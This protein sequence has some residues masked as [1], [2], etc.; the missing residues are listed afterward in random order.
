MIYFKYKINY[1]GKKYF[2]LL[3]TSLFQYYNK[4][5]KEKERGSVQNLKIKP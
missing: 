1:V 5:L 2:I 4:K 3:K